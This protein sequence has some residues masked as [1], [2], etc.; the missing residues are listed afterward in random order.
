[1]WVITDFSQDQIAVVL[2][3]AG[4]KLGFL[5][6]GRGNAAME[7]LACSSSAACCSMIR[8]SLAVSRVSKLLEASLVTCEGACFPSPFS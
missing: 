7:P 1:M 6:E 8:R 2:L 4:G 3:L 5:K